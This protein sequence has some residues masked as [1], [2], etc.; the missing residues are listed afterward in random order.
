MKRRWT[1]L[2]GFPL[3]VAPCALPRTEARSS[4]ADVQERE[5]LRAPVAA[6]HGPIPGRLSL[7]RSA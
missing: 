3:A 6:T 7:R 1:V 4:E 2:V 5:R